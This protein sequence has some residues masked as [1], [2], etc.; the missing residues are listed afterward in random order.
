MTPLP[1]NSMLLLLSFALLLS[2]PFSVTAHAATYTAASCNESAVQAAYNTEQA[3][4]ANGDIIAIPAGTCIWT[5]ALTI[6]PSNTLTIQGAG[7]GSTIIQDGV[8]TSTFLTVNVSNVSSPG[9]AFRL[10]GMS[11]TPAAG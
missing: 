10:S 9:A 6:T 7:A 2:A 5:T 1:R 11:F 8:T 3:S 4:A